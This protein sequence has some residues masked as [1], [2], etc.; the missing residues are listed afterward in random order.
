MHPAL[1]DDWSRVNELLEQLPHTDKTYWI[2]RRCK[3]NLFEWDLVKCR[4][5]DGHPTYCH[6]YQGT[7]SRY[8]AFWEGYLKQLID[9]NS[10]RKHG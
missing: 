6:P 7:L 5:Y 4:V 8:P 9:F 2:L 3:D 10:L 1:C